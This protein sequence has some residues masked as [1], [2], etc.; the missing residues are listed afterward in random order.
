MEFSL[1][2]IANVERKLL[3]EDELTKKMKPK[4][5]K[6]AE[7]LK[8]ARD[9]GRFIL[10]RFHHDADGISG[11]FALSEVLRFSAQQQN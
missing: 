3:V 1:G 7:V 8:S 5:K 11:A 6:L 2:E 4:I 9:E 10:L